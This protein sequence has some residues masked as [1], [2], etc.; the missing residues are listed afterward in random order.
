ME[1]ARPMLAAAGSQVVLQ[2]IYGSLL[3]APGAT[4]GGFAGNPALQHCL[5]T[6]ADVTPRRAQGC[7]DLVTALRLNDTERV[8]LGAAALARM[9][10]ETVWIHYML[11]DALNRL[12]LAG[13]TEARLPCM[14]HALSTL[15]FKGADRAH[16]GLPR[17]ILARE[18]QTLAP[19]DALG[20]AIEAML[21][22]N[23]S[24][25]G[26]VQSA[27]NRL[28]LA[29]SPPAARPDIPQLKAIAAQC[30]IPLQMTTID[31]VRL[32]EVSDAS[33]CAVIPG[34]IRVRPPP[35][36]DGAHY[37]FRDA[38][39]ALPLPPIAVHE[40]LG[41]TISFDISKP[42]RVEFYIF[43]ARQRCIGELSWG[44]N[45]FIVDEVLAVSGGLAVLGDR[46]SGT[47]NIC[48]FLLDNCSRIAIFRRY[49]D[50]PL[51]YLIAGNY[52]YYRDILTLAG[53]A[54][55]VLQPEAVR[56]SVRA[57]ALLV[58]SNI[59]EDL[60]HPAHL[61][62]SWALDFL[63][64]SLLPADRGG[65]VRKLYVKRSDAGSR[66]VLNEDEVCA[67]MA[68]HGFESVALS[69]FDASDQIALF[70]SA[71]H[72]VGVHGAGLTNVLFCDP[73]TQV[74][75]IV[76]P[77]VATDAYWTLCSQLG[78]RYTAMIA[79]DPEHQRPD[80]ATWQHLPEYGTRNIS[81]PIDRLQAV[82][83][84]PNWNV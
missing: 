81:M 31:A 3:P 65:A 12:A 55:H 57:D 63:R 47:M 10:Y 32:A 61:C 38:G 7:H 52:P 51:T 73:G 21:L 79:E 2:M 41:G 6:V 13:I 45:P 4:D 50:R 69:T 54:N 43:D 19:R 39:H 76:P 53:Y 77:M 84:S 20:H 24:T 16:E 37:I 8:F 17:A 26:Q 83:R 74:L 59:V 18:L 34:E 78:H 25:F 62:A 48:H 67:T 28:G 9:P 29:G 23:L 14:V 35:L 58:S 27:A 33:T 71:S 75:E 80:Y 5:T 42:G 72:V 1:R 64:R 49:T 40:V 44:F 15:L 22:G 66:N 30:E 82:L 36:G 46:F 11:T 60:R 56:F 68:Q 70:Q